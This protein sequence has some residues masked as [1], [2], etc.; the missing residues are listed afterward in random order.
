MRQI[1]VTKK[2]TEMTRRL[3]VGWRRCRTGFE[4]G[5]KLVYIHR[6]SARNCGNYVQTPLSTEVL[7]QF[8]LLLNQTGLLGHRVKDRLLVLQQ[9]LRRVEF[10]ELSVFEYDHLLWMWM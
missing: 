9:L 4:V 5:R 3:L 1:L 10:A 2:C 8:R 7:D 6:A